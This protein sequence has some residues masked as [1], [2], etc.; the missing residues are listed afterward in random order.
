MNSDRR[1]IRLDELPEPDYDEYPMPE[2]DELEW[3]PADEFDC[4]CGCTDE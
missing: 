3:T 4:P 1:R 2:L